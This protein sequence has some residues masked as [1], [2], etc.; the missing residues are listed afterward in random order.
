MRV[1]SLKNNGDLNQLGGINIVTSRQS[2][3]KNILTVL[4]E[5]FKF[6]VLQTIHP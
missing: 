3:M 5:R 1:S 4:I 2:V 6:K